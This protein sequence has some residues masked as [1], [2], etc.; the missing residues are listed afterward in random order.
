MVGG[1]CDLYLVG[2]FCGELFVEFEPF[3]GGDGDFAFVG[4]VVEVDFS[5]FFVA[6][7]GSEGC[8]FCCFG[9]FADLDFSFAAHW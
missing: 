5:A 6:A 8:A 3:S 9:G 4:V 2:G 1:V 7:E